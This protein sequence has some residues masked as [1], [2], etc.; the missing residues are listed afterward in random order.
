MPQAKWATPTCFK[1]GVANNQPRLFPSSSILHKAGSICLTFNFFTYVLMVYIAVTM[2]LKG[3][4]NKSLLLVYNKFDS[5]INIYVNPP[6]LT[7]ELL[8]G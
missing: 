1:I 5:V 2:G 6:F 4:C 7:R 8:N 3:G